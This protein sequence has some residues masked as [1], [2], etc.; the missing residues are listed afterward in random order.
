MVMDM[1]PGCDTCSHWNPSEIVWDGYGNTYRCN[2]TK[3]GLPPPGV[4]EDE[5][6]EKGEIKRIPGMKVM[7]TVK[8]P[9]WRGKAEYG[10]IELFK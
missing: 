7:Q 5:L 8:C 10:Q 6:D 3:D 2:A 1:I 9:L 4:G